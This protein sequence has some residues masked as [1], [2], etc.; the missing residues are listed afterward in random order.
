MKIDHFKYLCLTRESNLVASTLQSSSYHIMLSNLI[1]KPFLE[2]VNF[3]LKM[4]N[5]AAQFRFKCECYFKPISN[6]YNYLRYMPGP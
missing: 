2:D 1:L 6:L 5:V 4:Q 3:N